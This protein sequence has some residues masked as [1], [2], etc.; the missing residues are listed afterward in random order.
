MVWFAPYKQ[1]GI[2]FTLNNYYSW[3]V[4]HLHHH[5]H[6]CHHQDYRQDQDYIVLYDICNNHSD[7]SDHCPMVLELL[8]QSLG[9]PQHCLNPHKV[10]LPLVPLDHRG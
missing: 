6:H 8:C 7:H 2:V 9:C 4:N 10:A 1:I 3:E 5:H